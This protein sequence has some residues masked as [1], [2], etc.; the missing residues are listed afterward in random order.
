MV[1]VVQIRLQAEGCPP[2]SLGIASVLVMDIAAFTGR[3]GAVC[4]W[5]FLYVMRGQEAR[6][7]NGLYR[8]AGASPGAYGCCQVRVSDTGLF[9]NFF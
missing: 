1:E 2:F 9:L 3:R 4:Q 5:Q 8:C 6:A 7:S